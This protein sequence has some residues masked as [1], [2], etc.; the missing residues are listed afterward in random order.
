M[1]VRWFLNVDHSIVLKSYSSS[2]LDRMTS[3]FSMAEAS[4]SA[5]QPSLVLSIGG[6]PGNRT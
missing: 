4:S 5:V 6:E 2:V 3:P 1:V